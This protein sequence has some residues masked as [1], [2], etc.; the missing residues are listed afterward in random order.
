MTQLVRTLRKERGLTL[1][2]LAV[3]TGLTKSYLSKIERGQS[4]PSIAAAMKVAKAL[5]VDVGQLFADDASGT[6]MTVDRAGS[7]AATERYQAIAPAM[8]G[9]RMSP[10]LV[11]PGTEFAADPHPAHEGQELVFVISGSIELDHAGNLVSLDTGD[12][13]YFDA[14]MGH[15][16]RS[17][18]GDDSQVLVVA[19]N[20][21]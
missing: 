20:E 15:K 17:T 16:I 9:K 4:N 8:L 11:R 13:A 5:G 2:M 14:S 6:R 19:F 7:R 3:D 10:F 12:C 21:T 18:A 1:E